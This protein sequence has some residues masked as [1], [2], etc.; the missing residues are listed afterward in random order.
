MSNKGGRQKKHCL[1][2]L[3]RPK[4]NLGKRANKAK[5]RARKA[6]AVAAFQELS[7]GV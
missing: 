4:K 6:D 1:V 5:A 3:Q 2:G 7:K